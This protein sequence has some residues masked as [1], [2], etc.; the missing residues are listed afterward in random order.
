MG[1]PGGADQ[2]GAALG[3][4]ELSPSAG[5]GS[6]SSSEVS[7]TGGRGGIILF[8]NYLFIYLAVPHGLRNLSSRTGAL[9]SESSES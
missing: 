4:R 2:D 9:S 3:P 8:F 1:S 7:K 6:S 5:P